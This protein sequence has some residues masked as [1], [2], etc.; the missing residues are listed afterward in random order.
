MR[1]WRRTKCRTRMCGSAKSAAEAT[2]RTNISYVCVCWDVHC[3]I[4]YKSSFSCAI[5]LSF[6]TSLAQMPTYTRNTSDPDCKTKWEE[7]NCY[8]IV[9]FCFCFIFF[10]FYYYIV[11][12]FFAAKMREIIRKFFDWKVAV[13]SWSFALRLPHSNWMRWKEKKK[14]KKASSRVSSFEF[15]WFASVYALCAYV[16]HVHGAI[17]W[18]ICLLV[19]ACLC[20][21]VCF[22]YFGIRS[23]VSTFLVS[24]Y[25]SKCCAPSSMPFIFTVL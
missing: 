7:K 24:S 12:L 8:L 4:R 20:V 6:L 21:C 10:F 22:F 15:L 3:F 25:L 2:A 13:R 17:Y 1:K 16:C 23:L 14:R 18:L 9:I 19:W 11:P 5:F